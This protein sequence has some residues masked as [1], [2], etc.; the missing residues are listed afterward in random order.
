M[1]VI[2]TNLG[3]STTILWN[4]KEEQTGI[5]K[6][7]TSEAIQLL[8]E[9]VANDTVIDRKHHGG[10]HKACYLY[11]ADQYPYWKNH[12]PDLEWDWG[13]FGEN[14]TIEGLDESKLRIG[15]TYKL[16]S[17]LVQITQPREP[18][19]KLGIR[20]NDSKIIKKFVAHN[21]PGTYIKVL[22]TGTVTTGDEM[23]LISQSENSLTINQYYQFLF[24]K[25]KDPEVI[26]LI[27]SND[28][29][30]KYKKERL[31]NSLKTQ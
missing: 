3:K 30:P 22:E 10:V 12:Y 15:S 9:D 17:A 27:L 28:A 7:P 25:T 11:S 2:S 23:I 16:G 24:A 8:N 26:Q 4:G 1:K 6:Y 13:M 18:C 21:Y 31:R 19:Y 14:L 29:L 5:Y 20:F